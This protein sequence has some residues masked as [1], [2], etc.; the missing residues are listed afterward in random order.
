VVRSEY[1]RARHRVIMLKLLGEY[2]CKL[3][4][5]GRLL[6]PAK[7]RKPLEEVIHHGL[8][9][10]RDIYN[11]CLV[12]YPQPTWERISTDLDEMNIYSDK[13]LDFV[14]YFLNG[15]EE[16]YLDSAGRINIPSNL[17]EYAEVDLKKNN[18][19]ILCG[20]GQKM[21]LW[22]KATREKKFNNPDFNFASL[23]KEV[24]DEIQQMKSRK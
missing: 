24:K 7:L 1:F 13:H 17:L 5:K 15:A 12:L 11:K 9:I 20:L 18:E 8:V 4:N 22:S 3:D 19:L 23:A 21:E 14:R 16:V 10:N 6:F 2:P